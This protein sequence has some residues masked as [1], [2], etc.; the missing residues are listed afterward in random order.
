MWGNALNLGSSLT[1]G[2]EQKWPAFEMLI[3][4]FE[5]CSHPRAIL[6]I[7]SFFLH[8]SMMQI[9]RDLQASGIKGIRSD[10]EEIRLQA[11][12]KFLIK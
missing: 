3:F 12:K 2:V 11:R 10:P 9:S 7:V 6:S 1:D 8:T 4:D 5:E